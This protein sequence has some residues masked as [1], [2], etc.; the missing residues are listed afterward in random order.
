MAG[1]R[2]PKKALSAEDVLKTEIIVNQALVDILMAKQVI[3][4]EELIASIRKIR[5]EQNDLNNNT[6]KIVSLKRKTP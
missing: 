6:E 4:E 2:S 1:H 5:Q 3:T